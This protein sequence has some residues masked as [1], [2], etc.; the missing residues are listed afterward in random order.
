MCW[1]QGWSGEAKAK[2]VG[3]EHTCR[4][5]QKG[6]KLFRGRDGP[7]AAGGCQ[8]CPELNAQLI[9]SS[10]WSVQDEEVDHEGESITVTSL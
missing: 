1:G 6:D 2:S 4:A 7:A 10:E 3:L 5:P 8:R 9:D